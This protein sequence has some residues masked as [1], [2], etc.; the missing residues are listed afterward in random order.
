ML[1]FNFI[2]GLNFIFLCSKLIIVYCHT[3]K[4]RKIKSKPR[5]KLNHNIHT[6]IIYCH[7]KDLQ[8]YL[9]NNVYHRRHNFHC[10]HRIRLFAMFAWSKARTLITRAKSLLTFGCVIKNDTRK[11]I[12]LWIIKNIS[13]STA[14]RIF[15]Y[16]DFSG[17][18]ADRMRAQMSAISDNGIDE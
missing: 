15:R 3:S 8:G 6:F 17:K 2:L 14:T 7:W 5:I 18:T 9:A 1:W 10:T 4:Q 16:L 12:Y 11:S 13:W